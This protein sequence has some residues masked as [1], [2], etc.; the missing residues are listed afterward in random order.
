MRLYNKLLIIIVLFI[1]S[2]FG[3]NTVLSGSHPVSKTDSTPRKAGLMTFKL[4]GEQFSAELYE[5][6]KP[7]SYRILCGN[8]NYELQIEWKYTSSPAD[9]REDI[10]DLTSRESIVSV[11]YINFNIP[12]NYIT[13]SGL[14]VVKSNNGS[15]VTGVFSFKAFAENNTGSSNSMYSF[16]D[17]TFEISYP[18]K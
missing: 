6:V 3:L 8:K 18:A 4:N 12:F 7:Y 5:E 13:S 17:G 16:T 1:F 9:I 14:V 15:T 10:F 2:A 11:K